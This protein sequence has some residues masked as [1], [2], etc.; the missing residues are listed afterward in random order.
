VLTPLKKGQ[1]A[2]ADCTVSPAPHAGGQVSLTYTIDATK[3]GTVGLGAGI[4]DDAGDPVEHDDT[5]D[6]NSLSLHAGE[7]QYTRKLILPD[8][9]PRGTYDIAGE[10]YP[11]G[12]VGKG[13]TL[14]DETCTKMPVS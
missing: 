9:L 7:Q 6:R 2:L 8:H 5:G 11:T 12:K 4:Y 13:E 1:V 14:T 3:A 10:V